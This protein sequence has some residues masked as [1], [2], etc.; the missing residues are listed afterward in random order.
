MIREGYDAF[1]DPYFYPDTTVLRNL[2]DIRD[3]KALEAFEVEVSTLRAE[4]PLPDGEFD[5]AHYCALHHHLFQD[6]YQWAGQY[7][8]VRIAKGDSIFCYPE[9]VPGQMDALFATIEGGEHFRGRTPDEFVAVLARFLAELNAIHPF[10][11][12]NGR[13]QLAFVGLMGHEFDQP[14]RLENVDQRTFLAGMVASFA[15]DLG[16]L[17]A[18]LKR[19]RA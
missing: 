11:E 15:G 8:T 18:A 4:Q 7:R 17:I 19:L 2:R 14:L 1:D 9:N 16:P 5:A 10:R 6:V 3:E 12:G 13:T